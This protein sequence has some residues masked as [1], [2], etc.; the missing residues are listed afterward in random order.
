MELLLNIHRECHAQRDDWYIPI[1]WNKIK[2]LVATSQ[3][4][5]S[6]KLGTVS[7]RLVI[8]IVF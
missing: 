5:L 8:F 7:H 2:L 3:S 4:F 6:L 1:H